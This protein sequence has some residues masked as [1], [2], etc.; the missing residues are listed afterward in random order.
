[1]T[2][3]T[4][5]KRASLFY[6]QGSSD[7]EYN[8]FIEDSPTTPG[9]YDVRAT[10]GRRGSANDSQYKANGV[11]MLQAESEFLKLK[12]AKEGKGYREDTSLGFTAPATEFVG[13][14]VELKTAPVASTPVREYTELKP[15]LLNPIDVDEMEAYIVDDNWLVQEK[16][17]GKRIMAEI[18]FGKVT[19]SNRQSWKCGVPQNVA[20]E[21]AG[22]DDCELDGEL[23]GGVYYLFDCLGFNGENL[24]DKSYT[25]R[26]DILLEMVGNRMLNCVDIVQTA[27]DTESKRELIE[28][29]RHKEGVVFKDIRAPHTAGRPNSGGPQRKCKFWSSATCIVTGVNMKRSVSVAVRDYEDNLVEVG[30]VTV[31]PNYELPKVEDLVEIKYLY[32][33]PGGSLY[34][35]QYLGV[36]D[37]MTLADVLSSLK[38]KSEDSDE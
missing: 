5:R 12:R 33:Y 18:T 15:Q 24:R 21:L 19:T 34:Q 32:Y 35:P 6:R 3:S 20:D 22:F 28:S 9:A 31:P 17:D 10:W 7:K 25:A 37:D 2:T 8:I 16:L 13:K 36:R 1:M 38:P 29:L 23:V 27:Y 4:V 26:F 30:N 11:T 14:L